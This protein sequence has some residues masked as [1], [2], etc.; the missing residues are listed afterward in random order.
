MLARIRKNFQGDSGLLRT[1]DIVDVSKWR[2]VKSLVSNRYIEL[3]DASTKP[4][5][6]PAK[7]ETK[8]EAKVETKVEEVKVEKTK[9]KK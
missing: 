3:V 5:T 2:N 4:E 9:S 8:A 1:G 7:A 6:K